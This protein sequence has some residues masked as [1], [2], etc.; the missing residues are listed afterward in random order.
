MQYF[1]VWIYRCMRKKIK[2]YNKGSRWGALESLLRVIVVVDSFP[3]YRACG[4]SLHSVIHG[5]I[6]VN[7][8][9]YNHPAPALVLR[10]IIVKLRSRFSQNRQLRPCNEWKIMVLGVIADIPSKEVQRPVV[11][12]RLS[13]R[14]GFKRCKQLRWIE[15]IMFGNKVTS[16]W[17]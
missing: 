4:M 13:R 9:I 8:E 6:V 17:V 5:D 1:G 7:D 15:D 16:S 11:G 14:S 12:V 2:L 10:Q 3:G